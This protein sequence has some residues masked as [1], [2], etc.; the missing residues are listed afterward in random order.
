MAHNFVAGDVVI[1]KSD[2]P[3]MTIE[4]IESDKFGTT[5]CCVWFEKFQ[6]KRMRFS[7]DALKKSPGSHFA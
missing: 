2:G 7:A 6:A 5:I 4:S 1:L 3:D